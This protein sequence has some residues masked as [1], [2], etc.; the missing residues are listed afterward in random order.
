M[1]W[2]NVHLEEILRVKC[3]VTCWTFKNSTLFMINFDVKFDIM[4]IGKCFVTELTLVGWFFGGSIIFICCWFRIC[5]SPIKTK[6]WN[7]M[8]TMAL[9]VYANYNQGS[10]S[11]LT[12][13]VKFDIVSRC[14]ENKN[15]LLWNKILQKCHLFIIYKFS[16]PSSG[17]T[18]ARMSEPQSSQ[19][20]IRK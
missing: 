9:I 14:F 4:W 17:H 15:K 12:K 6:F 8:H 19:I 10:V 18:A 3:L 20:W 16:N 1:C 2:R 5:D 13:C 11:P 7:K